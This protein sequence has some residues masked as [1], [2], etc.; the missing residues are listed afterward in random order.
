M[1][2]IRRET[3]KG[4]TQYICPNCLDYHEFREDF[5]EQTFNENFIFCR[6]CGARNGTGTAPT[7]TPQ[8]EWVSVEE[9]LPELPEKDWCSK[10]V[11]SCDKNGHVAPMI[12]ER[13]QVRG[14]MIERWKY[15]WDRIYDGAGITHWM[16]L[17][18]PP[19]EGNNVPNEPPN[20]PLTLEELREMDG[21]N[22]LWVH[23]LAWGLHKPRFMLVHS[24]SE[25]W[26]TCCDFDGFETFCADD[27]G[28]RYLLYRRPP[29]VSP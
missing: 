16:P 27:Y 24:V 3:E 1:G 5:G 13:A 11:I 28:E 18:A 17:P 29:E 15:H 26:W 8:N 23:N 14:K 25:D 20:E 12:W 2:W 6:R 10:M 9:R 7:L 19:G 4:T 21:V 22:A